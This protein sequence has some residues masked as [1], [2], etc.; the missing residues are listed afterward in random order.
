[1]TGSLGFYLKLDHAYSLVDLIQRADRID[2]DLWST[3]TAEADG[4]MYCPAPEI[5]FTDPWSRR[6]ASGARTCAQYLRMDC[7]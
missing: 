2:Y 3:V 6:A 5:P 7:R 4:M 1:M